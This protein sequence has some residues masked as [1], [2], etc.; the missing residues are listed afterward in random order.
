LRDAARQRAVRKLLSSMVADGK[1]LLY[2]G[3]GSGKGGYGRITIKIKGVPYSFS[4]HRLAY[5]HKYGEIPDGH[6]VRHLCHNPRCVNFEC[7]ASGTP[8]QNSRDMVTSGRSLNQKGEKNHN[9]KLSDDE[10]ANIIR[11]RDDGSGL[12]QIAL[13]Y[14]VH[15]ST[16]SYICRKWAYAQNY[17]DT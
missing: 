3:S 10:R 1:C 11:M 16:I 13:K 15:V 5:E 4:A 8:A 6:V 14:N 12:R 7:L 2:S 17:T 9:A